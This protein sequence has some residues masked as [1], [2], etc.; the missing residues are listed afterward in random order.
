M[1]SYSSRV[2]IYNYC[3]NNEN[4]HNFS[5]TDVGQ[6]LGKM[7]KIVYFFYFGRTNVVAFR[8]ANFLIY[9]FHIQTI[10]KKF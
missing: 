2:N 6:F 8:L 5:S 9:F 1:Q 10:N 7:C 4:L 3:S